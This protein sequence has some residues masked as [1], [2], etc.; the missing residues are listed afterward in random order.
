MG[1]DIALG[2]AIAPM[3]KLDVFKHLLP[4]YI[5][6]SPQKVQEAFSDLDPEPELRRCY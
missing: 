2:I 4:K 6:S 5:G 1:V 3:I